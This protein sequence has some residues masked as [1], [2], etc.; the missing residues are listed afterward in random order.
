[1]SR[2]RKKTWGWTDH[3]T[4]NAKQQK[5]FANK[6]VR[7]TGDTPN[8]GAYKKPYCSYNICDYKFLYFTMIKAHEHLELFGGKIYKFYR[9]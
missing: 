7:R 5:R 8:G 3:Q 2:S 9:K 1:M 6:R 4:P